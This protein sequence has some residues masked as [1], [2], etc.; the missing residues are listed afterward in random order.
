MLRNSIKV[1]VLLLEIIVNLI[2][3]EFPVTPMLKS[4][5][6]AAEVEDKLAPIKQVKN[7]ILLEVTIN[8]CSYFMVPIADFAVLMLIFTLN[9]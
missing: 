1:G 7:V 8:G 9:R 4:R 2:K 3:V 5:R 6:F